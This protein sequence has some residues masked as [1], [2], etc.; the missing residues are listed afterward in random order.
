MSW[1]LCTRTKVLR[2]F[3]RSRNSFSALSVITEFVPER[4]FGTPDSLRIYQKIYE[5][6]LMYP[7]KSFTVFLKTEFFEKTQFFR[8]SDVRKYMSWYINL[9]TSRRCNIVN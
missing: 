4:N 8:L 6:V 2:Y 3:I 5:L 7:D 9:Y 1:Y